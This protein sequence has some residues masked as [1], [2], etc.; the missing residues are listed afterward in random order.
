MITWP[1]INFFLHKTLPKRAAVKYCFGLFSKLMCTLFQFRVFFS[2]CFLFF[3]FSHYCVE[4][5]VMWQSFF[6][7]VI[8]FE[9]IRTTAFLLPCDVSSISQRYTMRKW[10]KASSL[11]VRSVLNN[12]NVWCKITKKNT[13]TSTRSKTKWCARIHT[14]TQT[15]H[16]LQNLYKQANHIRSPPIKIQ[17]RYKIVV[18]ALPISLRSCVE[19]A[20][21]R[22]KQENK[23]DIFFFV[24]TISFCWFLRVCA[25]FLVSVFLCTKCNVL[26]R[27]KHS[28]L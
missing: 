24:N 19:Q 13:N 14:H 10:T 27:V 25:F 2:S 1:L 17:F 12:F 8:S 21:R 26:I 20:K 11:V 6:V 3:E 18:L 5:S 15:W 16:L 22:K 23:T 9:F 7:V 4:S 28:F